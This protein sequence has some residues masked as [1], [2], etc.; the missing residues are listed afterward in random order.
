MTSMRRLLISIRRMTARMMSLHTDPVEIIEP[1]DHLGRKVFQTA[2]LE[3]EVAFGFSRLK[4]C[5][6]PLL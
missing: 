2:D 4:R 1:Q 3:S 6:M 5:L